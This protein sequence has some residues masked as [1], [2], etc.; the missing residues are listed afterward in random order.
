MMMMSA[1]SSSFH[2]YLPMDSC[3]PKMEAMTPIQT[4][5]DQF[6]QTFDDDSNNT[7]NH[8]NNKN[9]T[10]VKRPM[11]AFLLWARGERKRVSSDGYGVSQTSLSKLLGET[12]RHMSVEEK[13]PFLDMAETL[14]RQHHIDHPDYKFKPKQRSITNKKSHSFTPQ[15]Q[16]STIIPSSNSYSFQP[17][18]STSSN[19]TPHP[20]QSNVLTMCQTIISTSSSS[21]E[22]NN[23][24]F[25]QLTA[26]PQTVIVAPFSRTQTSPI[27]SR[28]AVR[29][30]IINK[31]DDIALPP[32]TLL[33]MTPPPL[34]SSSS[35]SFVINGSTSTL[36]DYLG[37]HC[38]IFNIPTSNNQ[39]VLAS[40]MNDSNEYETLH[41]SSV[42]HLVD[43]DQHYDSSGWIDTPLSSFGTNSTDMVPS[44]PYTSYDFLC[45]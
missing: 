41:D 38:N 9:S 32:P 17:S 4:I 24:W 15:K 35:S 34:I 30:Q 8:R 13:Q 28:R 16:L 45:L 3:L 25:N 39:Q 5:E 33:P 43:L 37:D 18:L 19:A 7:N 23:D 44:S 21:S 11:N 2:D 40:D 10:V 6:E 42:N 31:H 20:V 26:Q 22:N 27:S 36:V 12:W 14:K 29:I 1:P